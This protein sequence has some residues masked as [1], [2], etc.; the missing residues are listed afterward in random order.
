MIGGLFSGSNI[1]KQEQKKKPSEV[2]YGVAIT[3]QNIIMEIKKI[4]GHARSSVR[5][6]INQ[7]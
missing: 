4:L 2:P 6:P 5:H 1:R 3:Q 7:S